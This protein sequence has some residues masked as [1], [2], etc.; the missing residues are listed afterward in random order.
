VSLFLITTAMAGIGLSINVAEL[1]RT[2]ARPLLLGLILWVTVA[3]TSLLLQWA[4]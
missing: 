3:G 1:R 4:T 2:G